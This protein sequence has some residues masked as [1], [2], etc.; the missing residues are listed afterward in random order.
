MKAQGKEA[1]KEKT[2]RRPHELPSKSLRI[3]HSEH[4]PLVGVGNS[5]SLL[6]TFSISLIL[7]FFK[8]EFD[9]YS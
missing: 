8:L 2:R 1:S 9:F 5:V 3:A 6:S 4:L 7:I